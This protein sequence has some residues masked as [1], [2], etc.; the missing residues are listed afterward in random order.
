MPS[1][2]EWEYAARAGMLTDFST[3]DCI[4][5]EQANY[6]Y[7]AVAGIGLAAPCVPQ[8]DAAVALTGNF[9]KLAFA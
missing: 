8:T 1:E 4:N 7:A 3:G 2:A 9:P 5:T 6:D